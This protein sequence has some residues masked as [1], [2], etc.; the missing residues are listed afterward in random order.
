MRTYMLAAFWDPEP[1]DREVAAVPVT[2]R[3]ITFELGSGIPYDETVQRG[4]RAI[5][6]FCKRRELPYSYIHLY[7][8]PD[9]VKWSFP[10]WIEKVW[11]IQ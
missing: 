8:I 4:V 3:F 1:S 10:K 7:R 6:A 11:P 2:L 9:D 5:R